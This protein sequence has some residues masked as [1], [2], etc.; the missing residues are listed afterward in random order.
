MTGRNEGLKMAKAA[1]GRARIEQWLTGV[2][3]KGMQVIVTFRA[4]HPEDRIRVAVTC[5]HNRRT[6]PA[7]G[8]SPSD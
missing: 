5:R 6:R 1:H 2:A 8:A 7:D 3:A 4:D